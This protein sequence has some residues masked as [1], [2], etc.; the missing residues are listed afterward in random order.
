MA[1]A[2]SLNVAEILDELGRDRKEHAGMVATTMNML[3]FASDKNV[4]DVIAERV[5]S[6]A[7][8]HPCRVLFLDDTHDARKHVVQSDRSEHVDI[9]VK[10]MPLDVLRSVVHALVVPNVQTVLLWAGAHTAVDERFATL[11]GIAHCI[12]LD[13]S[14]IDSTS[15]GLRELIRYVDS[16]G[17]PD[18]RDLAYMRLLP[19]QDMIAQFFDEADLLADLPAIREIEVVAGSDA[20]AYYLLGWLGSRL[21][22][23]PCDE[24][25]FCNADGE[26]V[27]CTV[28]REGQAR[29]VVRVSLGAPQSTFAATLE[30]DEPDLV[31][32][33]VEGAKTRPNRCAPLRH[34]DVVT[35][36]E[37]AILVPKADDVFRESFGTARTMLAYHGCKP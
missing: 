31:C 32:L 18:I 5:T 12:V 35:L 2:V 8:K 10:K 22:W 6:I 26:R 27:Q 37:R 29:R 23:R 25:A 20:E 14:R 15:A 19:W 9:G 16:G 4:R 13:S 3:V 17:R 30:K 28:R 21:G 33:T 1:P 11:A 24:N 7:E 36:I 34:V